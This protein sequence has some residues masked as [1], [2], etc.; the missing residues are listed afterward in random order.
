[1]PKVTRLLRSWAP[2]LNE[3]FGLARGFD[4]YEAPSSHTL[5]GSWRADG[6][7]RRALAWLD[8]TVDRPV[9]LS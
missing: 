3:Q 2:T 4:R 1:M 8:E 7:T 6:I 5:V 9:F